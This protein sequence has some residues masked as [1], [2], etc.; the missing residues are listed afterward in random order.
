MV[1]QLLWLYYFYDGKN[2]LSYTKKKT[3]GKIITKYLTYSL[4]QYTL[5]FN[6]IVLV[7]V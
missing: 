2:M 5:N 3:I 6:S 1:F 7:L 4:R